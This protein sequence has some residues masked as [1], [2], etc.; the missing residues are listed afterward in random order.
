M[1]L[2]ESF[3]GETLV[4]LGSIGDVLGPVCV[5]QG[6]EGLLQVALGWGDCGDNGGLGTATQGVLEEA[7]QLALPAG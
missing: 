3:L 7:S 2:D 5:V 1:Y 6:A 4:D